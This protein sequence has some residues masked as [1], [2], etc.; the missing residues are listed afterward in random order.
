MEEAAASINPSRR[1]PVRQG[2][3]SSAQKPQSQCNWIRQPST[4]KIQTVYQQGAQN[5]RCDITDITHLIVWPREVVGETAS[6]GSKSVGVKTSA[7]TP[8]KLVELRALSV[9]SLA[10]AVLPSEGSGR[11]GRNQYYVIARLYGRNDGL[12]LS[13]LPNGENYSNKKEFGQMHG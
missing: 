12:Q 13:D 9:G 10:L 6:G 7:A 4:K 11:G 3:G 5:L 1:R 2:I 8:S